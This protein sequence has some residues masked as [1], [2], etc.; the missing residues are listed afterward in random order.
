MKNPVF[1]AAGS[2]VVGSNSTAIATPSRQHDV[3][4]KEK[5][6]V[7][8][9]PITRTY[10]RRRGKSA[11]ES[12]TDP[13]YVPES[14]PLSS[15]EQGTFHF[16]RSNK[17]STPSSR[18]KRSE[19]MSTGKRKLFPLNKGPPGIP[20]PDKSYITSS[21]DH[22][23]YYAEQ[24]NFLQTRSLDTS[25]WAKASGSTLPTS[26]TMTFRPTE[27]MRIV[28]LD[29][30]AAAYIF[31]PHMDQEYVFLPALDIMPWGYSFPLEFEYFLF[32]PRKHL[33]RCCEEVLVPTPH[34]RLTRKVLRSLE[35]GVVV[36]DAVLTMLAIM[37][38]RQSS[39]FH[40]FVPTTLVVTYRSHF[41]S[42]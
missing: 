13:T 29:L 25:R 15:L 36:D 19:T 2:P 24:Q 1:D 3:S 17:R 26:I 42:A 16:T 8:A 20:P 38:H 40:W 11:M 6:A 4:G 31:L 37:L 18:R 10:Q 14:T 22:C 12:T 28:G 35:P 41:H 21:S 5:D 23:R 30:A 32:N 33:G 27:D 34:C 39:E 7:K 9:P